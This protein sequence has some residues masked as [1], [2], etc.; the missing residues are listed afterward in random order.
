MSVC[1]SV[2]LSVCPSVRLSVRPVCMYVCM[3]ACMHGWMDGWMGHA[4]MHDVCMYVWYV[5]YTSIHFISLNIIQCTASPRFCEGRLSY[6]FHPKKH[7]QRINRHSDA[8]G[9]PSNAGDIGRNGTA[10]LILYPFSA[11]RATLDLHMERW[12]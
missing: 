2:R 4:C 8:P 3:H 5:S 9:I 6:F 10:A 12:R 11:F 7:S 1:L